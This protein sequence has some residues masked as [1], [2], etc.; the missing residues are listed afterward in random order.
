MIDYVRP[1]VVIKEFLDEDGIVIPYGSRWASLDGPEE[2][3]SVAKHPE[4]FQPLV[5]VAHAIVEHLV[6]TY[7]VH[8]EDPDEQT[9][10]LRPIQRGAAPLRFAFS[11]L[12]SV[13]VT[14]GVST[15][16]DVMC[17]CDHCD[18]GV[19]DLV[20]VLEDWISAVVDG[21]LREWLNDPAMNYTGDNLFQAH[22]LR[23]VDGE[24]NSSGSSAV[25]GA[26]DRQKL[27]VLYASVPEQWALWV[28][29][30]R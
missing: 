9:V 29:R 27:R 23:S 11:S 14:G 18:E 20:D 24:I 8:R 10:V 21:G 30:S 1:P 3:Y 2:T 6:A 13:H 19:L 5:D 22:T 25:D 28:L 15:R 4:R 26:S 7:D 12:P 16:L 17:G